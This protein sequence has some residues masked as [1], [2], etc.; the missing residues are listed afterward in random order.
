MPGVARY[1]PARVSY[2]A[3]GAFRG[4]IHTCFPRIIA[5]I[6]PQCSSALSLCWLG[7]PSSWFSLDTQFPIAATV[8]PADIPFPSDSYELVRALLKVSVLGR[9][10]RLQRKD[11]DS[12]NTLVALA[13]LALHSPTLYTHRIFSTE[14]S[15]KKAC[16][17]P[18]N[19]VCAR[20][21][22]L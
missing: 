17:P 14:T 7:S 12:R 6:L 15:V 2:F 13:L 5:S 4:D 10:S 3:Y 22:W 11:V 16:K 9:S 19:R 8:T 21:R 18:G 1:Y 20:A